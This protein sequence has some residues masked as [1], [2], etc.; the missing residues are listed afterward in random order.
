[1]M[2]RL[3][4]SEMGAGVFW[5]HVHFFFGIF[6]LV[7]FILLTVWALKFLSASSLKSLSKWLLIIGILGALLSAPLAAPGVHWKINEW[8]TIQ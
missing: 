5:L 8:K 2:N 6:A 1:M 3:P 4:L 7:G